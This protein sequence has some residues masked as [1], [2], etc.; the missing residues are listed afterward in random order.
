LAIALQV[1]SAAAGGRDVDTEFSSVRVST[2]LV[3]FSVP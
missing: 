2:P 3:G 1:G